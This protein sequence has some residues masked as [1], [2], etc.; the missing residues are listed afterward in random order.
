[1]ELFCRERMAGYKL[2]RHWKAVAKLPR[3]GVGKILKNELRD[4][5]RRQS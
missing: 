4:L 1:M 3:N 2:P 5:L